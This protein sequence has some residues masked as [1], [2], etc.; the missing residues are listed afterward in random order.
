MRFGFRH[1]LP[2]P[3]SFDTVT[4]TAQRIAPLGWHLRL[5]FLRGTLIENVERLATL[6][7]LPLVVDHLGYPDPARSAPQ[8]PR[9]A[10]SSIASSTI[11]TGG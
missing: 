6:A 5:H 3:L 8:T 1:D 2:R 9:A 11:R 4:R 10:G 7:G